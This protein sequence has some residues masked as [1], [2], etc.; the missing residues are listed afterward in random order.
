M[1]RHLLAAHQRLKS[2]ERA[3]DVQLVNHRYQRRYRCLGFDPVGERGHLLF[4]YEPAAMACQH[5]GVRLVN[6]VGV[7]PRLGT[8]PAQEFK[9]GGQRPAAGHR[10]VIL[11]L[12]G[13]EHVAA[14]ASGADQRFSAA[15]LVLR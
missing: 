5:V 9:V 3:V 10:P 13:D 6:E 2:S 12:A 1:H 4:G 8:G 15:G 14:R 7:R 11:N